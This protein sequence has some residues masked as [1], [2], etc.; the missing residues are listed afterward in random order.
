M[1][2]PWALGHSTLN[3]L[4]AVWAKKGG[5]AAGDNG[6]KAVVHGAGQHTVVWGRGQPDRHGRLAR[7]QDDDETIFSRH[8]A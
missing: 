7:R 1:V 5:V 6:I 4:I 8:R 3:N 2:T